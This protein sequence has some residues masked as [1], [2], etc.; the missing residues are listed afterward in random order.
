MKE[1]KNQYGR[2]A[3]AAVELCRSKKISPISAWEEAIAEETTSKNSREKSCPKSAFLGLCEDGRI[4]E[5][6]P[7]SYLKKKEDVAN[8]T[9]AI[10]AVRLLIENPS[11][12]DNL[13]AL[14]E[15]VMQNV[16]DVNIGQNSQMAVVVALWNNGEIRGSVSV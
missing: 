8:K 15:K 14:W 3:L 2:A 13:T 9:Y 10:E 7:S 6:A 4:E 16:G 5:I 12:R 1:V 11:Q